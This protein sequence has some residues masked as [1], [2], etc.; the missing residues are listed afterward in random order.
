MMPEPQIPLMPIRATSS[1]KPSSS[2]Q[3]S[4]PITRIRGS[5]VSGSIR[6]LS[7]APGVARWPCVI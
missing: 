6:T 4:D 1:E 3:R 2:D 7:I 5:R